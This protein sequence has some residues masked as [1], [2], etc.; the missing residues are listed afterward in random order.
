MSL[1]QKYFKTKKGRLK[2]CRCKNRC[3]FSIRLLA[4]ILVNNSSR[5]ADLPTRM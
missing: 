3:R 5:V 4:N 1:A 2:G